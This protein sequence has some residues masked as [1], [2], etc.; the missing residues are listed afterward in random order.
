MGLS[1]ELNEVLAQYDEQTVKKYI[2]IVERVKV[3]AGLRYTLHWK[4]LD[5]EEDCK[6]VLDMLKCVGGGISA[7][8]GTKYVEFFPYTFFAFVRE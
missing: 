4:M 8:A 7:V 3:T 5:G 1:Q 2:E 6:A